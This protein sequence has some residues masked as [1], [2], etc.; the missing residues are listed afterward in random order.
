M[1]KLSIECILPGTVL[2]KPIYGP[3]NMMLLNKD[4][5]LTPAYLERLKKLGY[6]SL[7]V[8]DGMIDDV[9]ADELISDETQN[10]AVKYIKKAS[11]DIRKNTTIN[12]APLKNVITDIVDEITA[13]GQMMACL[14]DVS[15]YDDYTFNHSVNVTVL[16]VMIGMCMH[17]NR[18][19]LYDLGMGVLLHDIGKID[20]PQAII[21]KPDRLTPEEYQIVKNHTVLG[22]EKLRSNKDIKITSAHVA[23]QH[24]ERFD[25]S[26]YPRG[27]A[28][29]EIHEFA[30]IAAIA[31]VYDAMSNDRCYRQKIPLK[32]VYDYF[33]ENA[34]KL[35]DPYILDRFIQKI[36]V[37]PQGTLVTLSD[38]RSGLV[39]K[40]NPGEPEKPVVRLF[41]HCDGTDM[42]EPVEINLL[43][44]QNLSV[45]KVVDNLRP[46]KVS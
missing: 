20:I 38:G 15:S 8:Q 40:Q 41:W 16:S 39:I 21:T 24:H 32:E 30:R 25:G 45:Y 22:F 19:R 42:F 7:Y 27:L 2:A 6:C 44:E 36:A 18:A 14:S 43:K 17:Y 28:G 26:G 5:I 9:D 4:T 12:V 46:S 13:N 23:F 1:R 3:D 31:D 10:R 29:Q 33:I 35:F 34:G 37:Y 11:D